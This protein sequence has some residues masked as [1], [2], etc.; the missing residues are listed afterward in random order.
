MSEA[1]ADALW[2]LLAHRPA[3]A[4]EAARRGFHLQLSGHLH[5]GQFLPITWIM[6]W[7]EPFLAGL[8]R[9]GA[10]WLYVNRGAGYW[11]PPNRLGAR[12]EI[13]VLEVGA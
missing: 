2:V 10:M 13:T 3:D 7:T 1:P 12:Q 6:R 4:H 5:G 9:R 11:G 8:Y